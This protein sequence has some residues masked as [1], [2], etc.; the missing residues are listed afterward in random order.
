[1]KRFN[2]IM[3]FV[4]CVGFVAYSQVSVGV[5]IGA[6]FSNA[7]VSGISE[8]FMPELDNLTG[9]TAGVVAEIPVY[10]KFSF[11]PEL[12]YIEK[13]FSAK[14]NLAAL[15]NID[16]PINVRADVNYSSIEIPLLL[17]Y[18]IIDGNNKLYV[19]GG[20]SFGYYTDAGYKA[21]ATA[22]FDF[23]VYRGDIDLSSD[24]F[25][26]L[27]LGGVIGAGAS[28]KVLNSVLFAD[29]RY[30]HSFSDLM[31]ESIIDVRV[32]HSGIQ[33]SVGYKYAF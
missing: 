12:N 7:S 13:G 31:S 6:N 30:G 21:K 16:L 22:I 4:L 23:T 29:V 19:F 25:N 27:D 10:G 3:S 17:N 20:P 11:K 26:N 9:F 1:M 14:E 15:L 2:L 24:M 33:A 32:R 5:K 28:T 8:S 18:N